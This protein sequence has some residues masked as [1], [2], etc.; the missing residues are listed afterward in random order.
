M[1]GQCS[2]RPSLASARQ[3]QLCCCFLAGHSLCFHP[4]GPSDNLHQVPPRDPQGAGDARE[5]CTS[6]PCSSQAAAASGSA[7]MS[8]WGN[9]GTTQP[10]GPA[11]AP[12]TATSPSNWHGQVPG[13]CPVPG[14]P[15]VPP[16]TSCACRA[17]MPS[18]APQDHSRKDCLEAPSSSLGELPPASAKL[19]TSPSAVGTLKR[20][21]S[22]SRH[23]S[24]AGFPLTAAAPRAV[25]KGQKPPMSSSP[26]EGGEGP[27]IDPEDI[28]QLLTDVARFADA[29]EK[30]RDVVLRDGECQDA[31]R[32]PASPGAA[33]AVPNR[34]RR[35]LR[36]VRRATSPPWGTAGWGVSA[37]GKEGMEPPGAAVP[38][39]GGQGQ[40]RGAAAGARSRRTPSASCLRAIFIRLFS[41]LHSG[42]ASCLPGPPPEPC[43]APGIAPSLTH[44]TTLTVVVGR[45]GLVPRS[46]AGWAA[47]TGAVVPTPRW[48]RGVVPHS[49]MLLV[50]PWQTVPVENGSA[51]PGAPLPAAARSMAEL[52]G[53]W[54]C[55]WGCHGVAA[56]A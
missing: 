17:L 35:R 6:C 44:Q 3:M 12:Q 40:R 13:C 26:L 22:L 21:T 53:M 15:A 47:G 16:S 32:P 19:S 56:G 20:P 18:P 29:L 43:R 55:F 31:P 11:P 24:A 23:A 48:G 50:L 28:S 42:G 8:D 37:P 54:L 4:S 46:G 27:F 34:A 52:V 9:W 25:P 2:S 45:M 14:I 7:R 51:Q 1:A 5:G 39:P 33:P 30:L 49:A 38:A 41:C 36:G 10:R